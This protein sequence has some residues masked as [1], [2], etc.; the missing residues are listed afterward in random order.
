ML[1]NA[2]ERRLIAGLHDGCPEAEAQL[3][4][5][6]EPLVRHAV[7][8]AFHN[9]LGA[10]GVEFDDLLQAAREAVIVAARNFELSRS[11]RFSTYAKSRIRG[12]LQA[13]VAQA[14]PLPT[15]VKEWRL[16][17]QVAA[18]TH[19]LIDE[20]FTPRVSDVVAETA[21]REE[22]V[23]YHFSH[24]IQVSSLDARTQPGVDGTLLFTWGQDPR[25][26]V[27]LVAARV[28]RQLQRCP[29]PVEVAQYLGV[30][31]DVIMGALAGD[32]DDGR[33]IRDILHSSSR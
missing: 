3:L 20:G 19:R 25:H 1:T 12:A 4:E 2:E 17:R 10:A 11:N 32:P 21:A 9:G 14:E 18:I 31:L 22:D 29:V 30:D 27:A 26:S 33:E 7:A 24:M 23:V 6:F 8:F 15:P 5:A 13:A 28:W 16:Q